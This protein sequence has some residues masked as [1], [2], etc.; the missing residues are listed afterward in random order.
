[1]SPASRYLAALMFPALLLGQQGC[2]TVEE[3]KAA[4]PLGRPRADVASPFHQGE[5]PTGVPVQDAWRTPAAWPARWGRPS[6]RAP[7]TL[8]IVQRIKGPIMAM[9][10]DDDSAKKIE[11]E[12]LADISSLIAVRRGRRWGEGFTLTGE[13]QGSFVFIPVPPAERTPPGPT[14]PSLYYKFISAEREALGVG[15]NVRMQRSWFAYYDPAEPADKPGEARPARGVAVVLPGMFGTPRTVVEQVVNALRARGWGVLRLLAHPSRFTERAVFSLEPEADLDDWADMIADVLGGRAAECA[16]AVEEVLAVLAK[17]RPGL[18]SGPRLALGLSGGAMV[19]PTV[20]ARNPEAYSGAVL[21]AGGGDFL[22]VVLDSN[23]TEWID[24]VRVAWPGVSEDRRAV[25]QRELQ[26]RYRARSPLDSLYTVAAL[27]G[28]PVLMLHA[29]NDKAVPAA[30]GEEL[31]QRAGRPERWVYNTGH[32]F[33]FLTLPWELSRVMAWVDEHVPASAA[34]AKPAAS[35]STASPA[36][37]PT[38]PP[39]AP[40]SV[41]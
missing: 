18:A 1:M 19:L 30:L 39:S 2:V 28:K 15:D 10:S 13:G 5:A 38:P 12:M 22:G 31:W 41:N 4:G 34:T 14:S 35:T 36:P 40:A 16:Y 7:G 17:D 33:L 32:E 6:P 9:R 3:T 27:E 37:V 21:I 8:G 11:Q 26:R 20:V 24:A 23:Y 29:A 25:L